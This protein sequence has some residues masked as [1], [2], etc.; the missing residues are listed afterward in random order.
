MLP[1]HN[2]FYNLDVSNKIKKHQQQLRT[3]RMCPVVSAL[4]RDKDTG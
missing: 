2:S 4:V 3:N 1:V